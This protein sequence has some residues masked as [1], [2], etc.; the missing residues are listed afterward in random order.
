VDVVV[1]SVNGSEGKGS[2]S[3]PAAAVKPIPTDVG[4]LSP[5]LVPGTLTHR[6]TSFLGDP[7]VVAEDPKTDHT[8]A[9]TEAQYDFLRRLDG[10]TTVD[11]ALRGTIEAGQVPS[12]IEDLLRRLMEKG[13]LEDPEGE[14]AQAL[15]PKGVFERLE[16]A[17]WRFTGVFWGKAISGERSF[18]A[19]RRLLAG[20]ARGLSHPTALII[21]AVSYIAGFVLVRRMYQLG[22][23]GNVPEGILM[24]ED[25]AIFILTFWLASVFSALITGS[26]IPAVNGGQATPWRWRIY[27]G[28]PL[29]V[30][31]W[32]SARRVDWKSA[33]RAM[34]SGVGLLLMLAFLGTLVIG[35]FPENKSLW[36]LRPIVLALYIAAFIRLSP[37]WSSPLQLSLDQAFGGLRFPQDAWR[38]LWQHFFPDLVRKTVPSRRDLVFF[39]AGVYM[40][41]WSISALRLV[42]ALVKKQGVLLLEDAANANSP[43]LMWLL[44]I[45]FLIVLICVK[46]L[47]V[48]VALAYVMKGLRWLWRL[49]FS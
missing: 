38:Y 45:A 26:A 39:V 16:R 28:L 11:D 30:P 12:E 22:I 1:D 32:K 9:V 36:S 5:G 33:A 23:V 4:R 3:P 19:M 20:P 46:L 37:W 49:C 25:A 2:G 27:F 15:A 17:I 24:I 34:L 21:A 47:L 44:L 7:Y 41:F 40:L 29:P 18:G 35:I 43:V 48:A 42:A 6:F 8:E 13:L 31:E 10:R 14:L